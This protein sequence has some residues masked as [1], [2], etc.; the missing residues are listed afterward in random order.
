MR[1]DVRL[2]FFILFVLLASASSTFSQEPKP[3]PTQLPDS[4][5]NI[6]KINTA[7]IKVDTSLRRFARDT[8]LTYAFE[9]YNP[10][11]GTK[12][13]KLVMRSRLF[14]NGKPIFKGKD[15]PVKVSMRRASNT[16]NTRA[17]INLSSKMPLG[18]YILQIFVT[19][20]LSN[21]KNNIATQ[22]VRFEIVE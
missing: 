10:T 22:Y 8:V 1:F 6:V 15:K 3:S 7:L 12:S 2:T 21:R 20:T 19:D 17:A 18:D 4:D 14:Y 16:V 11:M 9:I 5:N 13:P